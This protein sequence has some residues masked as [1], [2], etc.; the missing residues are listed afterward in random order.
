MNTPVVKILVC[1]HKPGEWLSDDV[2]MPIQCGKAISQ[3]DL[4]IQGD[5]TGD[6][7]SAKNPYYCELTALYWAWKNLKNVDYI[8][9]CHYRRYFDFKKQ[10]NP[11]HEIANDKIESYSTKSL[12][13]SLS[14]EDVVLPYFWH[15]NV[16]V[17]ED[18]TKMVT[19]E[20]L[21]ILYKIISK[22]EPSY[23]KTFEKFM[24]GNRRTA[25]N[26]FLMPWNLFDNYCRWLFRLLFECEKKVKV[27]EYISYKRIYGYYAEFLLPVYFL[28]NNIR[29]I[30]QPCVITGVISPRKSNLIRFTARN[31]LNTLSYCLAGINKSD[32]LYDEYWE[33]YL[34]MDSIII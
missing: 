10:G 21:Y 15:T 34:K 26:M 24:T 12:Y 30:H 14:P 2:Y 7:I 16:R 31:I 1:C 29:I 17:W 32:T 4:G 33:M 23:T 6:N 25:F 5:D 22:Y 3:Y 20:D 19:Q 28:H 27:S 9:L 11:F 13:E 18:F 8:G